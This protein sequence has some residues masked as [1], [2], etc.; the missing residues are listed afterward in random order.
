VLCDS[1]APPE[2]N[3]AHS[4]EMAPDGSRKTHQE[5]CRCFGCQNCSPGQPSE[6]LSS[7][8]R[9]LRVSWRRSDYL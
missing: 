7:R 3:F 9:N 6:C 2:S 8:V 4:V 5:N 1:T